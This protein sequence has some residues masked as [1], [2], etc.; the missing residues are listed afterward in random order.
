[1]EEIRQALGVLVALGVLG[2]A[3][4]WLRRKGLAQFAVGTRGGGR[5]KSMK[6]V[7]RLALTPQHSL[8]LVR[9]G[10]RTILVSASPAGCSLVDPDPERAE[11]RVAS[12]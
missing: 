10:E 8:H 2:G 6:V 7:E 3:L 4:W 5:A 9:V 1:M 12:R 11:G